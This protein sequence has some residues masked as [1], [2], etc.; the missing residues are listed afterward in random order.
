MAPLP[1]VARQ[2]WSLCTS[3]YSREVKRHVFSLLG[4]LRALGKPVA[5]I[6]GLGKGAFDSIHE[7]FQV[8]TDRSQ[9]QLRRMSDAYWLGCTHSCS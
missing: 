4:S 8:R 7:P 3:H 1:H 2:M 5:L 6:R 9:N